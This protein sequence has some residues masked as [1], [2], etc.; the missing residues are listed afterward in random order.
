M[1]LAT[2]F[3]SKSLGFL[4]PRAKLEHLFERTIRFLR[5]HRSISAT[6]EQ[7]ARILEV[8]REVVFDLPGRGASLS[9]TD[10]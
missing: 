6:L 5:S 3:K 9:S 1:V 2:T 4:V 8:V 10:F 7:D